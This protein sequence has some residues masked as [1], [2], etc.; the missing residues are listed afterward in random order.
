MSRETME[1]LNRNVLVGY[2]ATRGNAW[3][4]RASEQG[5]EPNHYEGA[6]PLEDIRRRIFN[7]E[8]ISCPVFVRFPAT[9]DDADGINDDGTF[10]KMVQMEDRQ[11][12]A[13]SNTGK[14][15]NVFKAGYQAHQFED[16]IK[17]TENLI[18]D[19]INVGSAGILSEGAVG[20]IQIEMPE[21]VTVLEG[22]D[23]RPTL[24]ATTS[25]NGTLATT[26]KPVSTIVVCDNTHAS[27]MSEVSNEFK[28]RHSKYSRLRITDA[29]EA[30]GFVHEMTDNIIAEI[31]ALSEWKVTDQQFAK[32]VDK[33]VPVPT[34][35]DS[36]QTA[37]TKAEKK[38]AEIV[39]L[40]RGDARVAPWSGSALGVL[41]AWNTYNHHVAGT[42]SKRAERN[43]LNALNGKTEASDQNVLKALA[44]V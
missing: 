34:L 2:T 31:T 25:H 14:V 10:Y 23:V 1:W 16:L 44:S 15:F 27:A 18:D 7:F 38:R 21:S 37:I 24:L 32:L 3:H 39:S 9:M 4:W 8:A 26:L 17:I 30:L 6:I 42:D 12:I 5:D 19:S 43:M 33:L 13:H 36:N 22:F 28:A 41:Q 20:W 35:E 29:R 11:A 40:Y